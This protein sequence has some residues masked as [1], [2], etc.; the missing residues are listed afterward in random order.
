MLKYVLHSILM[1]VLTAEATAQ[2]TLQ[3]SW[4]AHRFEQVEIISDAIFKIKVTS[5]MTDTITLAARIEGEFSENIIVEAKDP[6]LDNGKLLLTIGYSPYFEPKNDKL[7]A[8][9]VDA[10]EMELYLPPQKDL[11]VRSALASVNTFGPLRNLQLELENGGCELRNFEGNAKLITQSGSILV[12]GTNFAQIDAETS[13]GTLV[14][15]LPK[16]GRYRLEVKSVNGDITLLS[17]Q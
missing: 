14:D 13:T 9:K 11:L 6:E 10:I 4:D 16:G 1:V 7:A 3:K 17:S 12:H 8:H 2:K 15:Q 5:E